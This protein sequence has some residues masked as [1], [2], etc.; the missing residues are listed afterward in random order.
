MCEI[1]KYVAWHGLQLYIKLSQTSLEIAVIYEY[2]LIY[3]LN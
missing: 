3:G 2:E 1:L